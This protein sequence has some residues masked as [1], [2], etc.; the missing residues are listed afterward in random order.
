MQTKVVSYK[1]CTQKLLQLWRNFAIFFPLVK[2]N[3][4]PIILF[5]IKRNHCCNYYS[6]FRVLHYNNFNETELINYE[7]TATY[8]FLLLSIQ[9]PSTPSTHLFLLLVLFSQM[10]NFW[11]LACRRATISDLGAE[12]GGLR[13]ETPDKVQSGLPP[14]VYEWMCWICL[15]QNH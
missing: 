4:N 15:N 7:V 8:P 10:K 9:F 13:R 3:R 12:G 14:A 2:T 5:V 6:Y 11:S 1:L